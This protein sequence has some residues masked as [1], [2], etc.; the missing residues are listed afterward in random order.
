MFEF[1][2]NKRLLKKQEFDSVFKQSK[3]IVSEHFIVFF[4]KNKFDYARLG[5][6]VS[7]K[8]ISR[9]HERNTIKRLARESFRIKSLLS[10]DCVIVV[11]KSP[12]TLSK[13]MIFDELSQ[14]WEN[15]V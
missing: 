12:M 14:A 11:R 4:R 7:K 8:K 6:A 13:L 9:A 10:Y 5:L 2:K 1:P 3:K 15:F